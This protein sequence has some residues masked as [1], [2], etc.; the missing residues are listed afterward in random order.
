MRRGWSTQGV[1]LREGCFVLAALAFAAA[2]VWLGRTLPQFNDGEAMQTI[3]EA[4]SIGA[5]FHRWGLLE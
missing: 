4:N 3:T 2:T 1:W 5:G